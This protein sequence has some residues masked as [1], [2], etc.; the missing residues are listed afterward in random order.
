MVV[1]RLV[2]QKIEEVLIKISRSVRARCLFERFSPRFMLLEHQREWTEHLV[3][4]FRCLVEIAPATLCAGEDHAA[5]ASAGCSLKFET[6]RNCQLLDTHGELVSRVDPAE[7]WL[8]LLHCHG[9]YLGNL[10]VEYPFVL[11]VIKCPVSWKQDS[12]DI[13]I[14]I[15]VRGVYDQLDTFWIVFSFFEQH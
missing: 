15:K 6:F 11:D 7:G 9:S 5:F 8:T 13:C 14:I 10:P 3:L 4:W 2:L 1:V 12:L